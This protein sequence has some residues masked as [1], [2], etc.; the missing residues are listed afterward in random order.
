M[1]RELITQEQFDAF[2]DEVARELG[3]HCRT[4]ELSDYGRGLGRLVIDGD[5]R[6]L[7]LCQPDDLRPERL[8]VYAALPDETEMIAPSIGVTARSARHVAREITR[9]LYPLH[10]EAAQR[11]AELAAQQKAEESGRRAVAEAVAGALPGARIEE[12]YRRTRIIWQHDTRPPGERG[13]VQVDSVC[14]VVGVSGK[15]VRVE[16]SGRPSTVIS[17]LAAFARTSQE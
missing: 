2:A 17:M 13:P 3:T 5:G 9:R 14:A 1:T 7:R 12:Q 10:G 16:A 6:A 15:S 8:K 11:A 4:A